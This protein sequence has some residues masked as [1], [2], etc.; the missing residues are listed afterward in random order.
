MTQHDLFHF[1]GCDTGFGL[2]LAKHLHS[3]GFTVFAGCLLAEQNGPGALE[4]RSV[5]SKRLRVLQLDVTKESDWDSAYET[6]MKESDGGKLWG[7]VNNAGW[8]TFGK[9]LYVISVVVM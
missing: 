3:L 7:I 2:T 1:S 8:S 4:L 5:D 9:I 6:V